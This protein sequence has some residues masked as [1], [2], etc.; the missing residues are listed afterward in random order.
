[1]KH[2]ELNG[3][4]KQVPTGFSWTT[5]L[6]GVFPALFRGDL[7]WFVIQLLTHVLIAALTFGV[8]LVVT[9]LVFAFIYNRQ[10]EKDLKVAGWAE[11][12]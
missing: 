12:S 6:F 1:M 11:K 7:K 8:G 9:W 10:Y 3:V 2:Y 5:L 4:T